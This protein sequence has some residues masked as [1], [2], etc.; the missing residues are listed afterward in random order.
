MLRF[1]YSMVSTLKPGWG[2]GLRREG[3]WNTVSSRKR[4]RS[5]CCCV[6]QGRTDGGDGGD[7]L[8][9][10]ELVQDGCFARRIEANLGV[11]R[12]MKEVRVGVQ[13][14]LGEV[15]SHETARS[16]RTTQR[17]PADTRVHRRTMTMRASREPLTQSK[18]LEME[19]PMMD[20]RVTLAEAV[21][22]VKGPACGS[23]FVASVRVC[24]VV[25]PGL[26]FGLWQWL[27]KKKGGRD[28]RLYAGRL[29]HGG[30]MWSHT[31]AL[32][33]ATS[34]AKLEPA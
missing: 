28:G 13:W 11:G 29:C 23:G 14:A 17:H 24:A 15:A 7:D 21:E 9:Q 1:L 10:A 34:R 12:G 32:A 25:C 6:G 20:R 30:S 19:R 27:I 4:W 2:R 26:C 18:S 31:A 8:A 3:G 5:A 22:G 16:R 33:L